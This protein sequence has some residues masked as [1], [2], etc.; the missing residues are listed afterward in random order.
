MSALLDALPTVG[1]AFGHVTWAQD[2]ALIARGT[3][4]WFGPILRGAACLCCGRDTHWGLEGR[5]PGWVQ[6]TQLVQRDGLA[7]V[8]QVPARPWVSLSGMWHM[9]TPT[10]T[11]TNTGS[12]SSPDPKHTLTGSAASM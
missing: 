5:P 7:S 4:Q 12:P 2:V 9:C 3:K 8:P 10:N 1:D 11:H 6:G